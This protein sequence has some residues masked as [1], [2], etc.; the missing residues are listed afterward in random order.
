MEGG[1]EITRELK[2]V[3]C[4]TNHEIKV[5]LI[6]ETIGFYPEYQVDGER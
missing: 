6:K 2:P 4:L 1:G 3:S 5:L